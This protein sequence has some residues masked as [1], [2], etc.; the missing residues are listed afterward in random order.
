M[1]LIY[2]TAVSNLIYIL[3][4]RMEMKP[5]KD[6]NKANATGKLF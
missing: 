3:L 5:I 4:I 6:E 2:R 1:Y